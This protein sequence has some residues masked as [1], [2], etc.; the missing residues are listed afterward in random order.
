M[1]AIIIVQKMAVM[2]QDGH[3]RILAFLAIIK[4]GRAWTHGHVLLAV[5][6][7][8]RMTRSM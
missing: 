1:L 8:L 7:S 6:V 2:V 5:A 4:I 3:F